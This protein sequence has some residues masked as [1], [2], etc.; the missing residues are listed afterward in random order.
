MTNNIS[1][2]IPSL[3]FNN[4]NRCL[5]FINKNSNYKHEVLVHLNY[6]KKEQ[7][8]EIKN[9]KFNNLDDVHVQYSEQNLGISIPTNNL[10]KKAKYSHILY[11]NDDEFV[12]Y[13]WDFILYRY[14]EKM[15]NIDNKL[16]TFR[17]IERIDSNK[18][19]IK[20]SGLSIDISEENLE[21]ELDNAEKYVGIS[22]DN[23]SLRKS[24]V[25][26]FVSKK[27][28]LELGGYDDKLYPGGGTD[29][30]FGYEFVKKYGIDNLIFLHGVLVYH[31][32]KRRGTENNNIPLMK[33]KVNEYTMF[34]KKYGISMEYFDEMLW[35][36][37]QLNNKLSTEYIIDLAFYLFTLVQNKE[38]I[39]W[40]ANKIRTELIPKN[41][42]EIGVERGGTSFI[43][44]LLSKDG[45]KIGVNYN[46][47]TANV[48]RDSV[49]SRMKMNNIKFI[50][51]DSQ[52][53]ET[54][55]KVK[56]ELDGELLD[57]LFIDG[58]HSYYGVKSDFE[59]Y[60]KL[61][62]IGGWIVFH[63]IVES[64][65]NKKTN[66]EVYKFWQELQGSKEEIVIEKDKFGIGVFIK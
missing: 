23:V 58:N 35:D 2:I 61:V 13:G 8:E 49:F 53:T 28:F 63:D 62:R 46:D 10:V 17:R 20:Y 5:Y 11:L 24:V 37:S 14:I 59:K 39:L 65:F 6:C 48:V 56:K 15:D 31:F 41:V 3:D 16:F 52:I 43:W 51:G 4:L 55:E 21:K 64:D 26:F 19:N 7:F 60:E 57:L 45:K 38:E 22:Y 44:N 9:W 18:N 1:I 66:C 25:P 36:F 47:V 29:S 42:L 30:H 33:S 32:S 54:F 27:I 40:V 34:I 50:E 12:F